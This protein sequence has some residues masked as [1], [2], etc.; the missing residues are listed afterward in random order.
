MKV[1][2]IAPGSYALLQ[3]PEGGAISDADLRSPERFEAL[4]GLRKVAVGDEVEGDDQPPGS[5]AM[6]L[7]DVYERERYRVRRADGRAWNVGA[8]PS[9]DYRRE[10]ASGDA[11][12]WAYT[13]RPGRV[14]I[15]ALA[16]VA[17][18]LRVGR[19][20]GVVRSECA[21]PCAIAVDGVERHARAAVAACSTR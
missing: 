8:D 20:T 11:Q 10:L 9:D 16:Q 7:G 18:V 2:D 5:L 17:R 13:H 1:A 15:L 12:W 3:P 4:L 21:E 6:R 14:R 19:R